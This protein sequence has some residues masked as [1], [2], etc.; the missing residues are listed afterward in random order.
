MDVKI[1]C[2]HK[3]N[4]CKSHSWPAISVKSFIKLIKYIRFRYQICLPSDIPKLKTRKS[5]L[6]GLRKY[7]EILP[8]SNNQCEDV[9][10]LPA[11]TQANIFCLF[12]ITS[13]IL[14]LI[15][16]R[17]AYLESLKS[18]IKLVALHSLLTRPGDE[19]GAVGAV[20]KQ[21]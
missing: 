8:H 21:T 20:L 3:V 1:L 12:S 15:T 6:T 16:L 5:P 7:P 17:T 4:N 19:A 9:Q 18:K 14:T 2:L 13:H 10:G 11:P